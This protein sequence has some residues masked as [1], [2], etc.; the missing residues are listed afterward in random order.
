MTSIPRTTGDSTAGRRLDIGVGLYTGQ[1]STAAGHGYRD[2]IALAQA[3]E[4]AGFDS[5]WVSEHHGWDD[6][7]LPSPLVLLAALASAT[8][9]GT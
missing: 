2:A 9:D 7:Y 4:E 3:A 5:F 8:A 1:G 6:A